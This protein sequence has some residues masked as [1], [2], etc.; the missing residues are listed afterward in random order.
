MPRG[1]VCHQQIV[2]PRTLP[3]IQFD[4][5]REAQVRDQIRNVRR[6]NDRRSHAARAQIVLHNRSQRWPMQVIEV[7]M[8]NQYQVDGWKIRNPHAW[9]AKALQHKQPSRKIRVDHHALAANLHEKAC[10]ADKGNTQFSVRGETWFVS[11]P[12]AWSDG[13]APHETSELR[14]AFT[15]SRITQRLFN[16][17]KAEPRGKSE[18][19]PQC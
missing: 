10:V 12:A 19:A 8:R 14:G 13:G 11:L 9:P 7:R 1:N 3:P 2:K 17:P 4:N 6:D 16:H 18:A 5:F 15:E